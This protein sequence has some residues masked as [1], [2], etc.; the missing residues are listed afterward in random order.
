M[1]HPTKLMTPASRPVPAESDAPD[2]PTL[3]DP[4]PT[5]LPLTAPRLPRQAPVLVAVRYLPN[6]VFLAVPI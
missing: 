6:G 2:I 5:G 4:A 3:T 1:N